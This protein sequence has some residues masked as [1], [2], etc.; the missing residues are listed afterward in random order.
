MAKAHAQGVSAEEYARQVLADA[1][2]S[3]QPRQIWDVIAENMRQVPPEDLA[4]LPRDGATQIDH[5][6]YGVPKRDV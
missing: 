5:C 4:V 2:G 3:S 1:L 6:V